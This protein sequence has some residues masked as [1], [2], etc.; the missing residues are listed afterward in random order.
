MSH[1]VSIDLEIMDLDALEQSCPELG[2]IFRRD[3]KKYKWYG[4]SMGDYPLPAGMTKD[5]LGKCEHAI[6]VVGAGKDC[7]EIGIY[8]RPA[9][10]FKTVT[11]ADGTTKQVDI[12]GTYGLVFDFWNGG[13]GLEAKCGANAGKLAQAYAREVAIKQAKRQ[14]FAVQQKRTQDGKIQLVLTR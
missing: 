4:A 1:L 14:G 7:Y 3:Q 10:T 6:S 12:S 2:L 8:R 9:G 5:Q 11:H 13:Y